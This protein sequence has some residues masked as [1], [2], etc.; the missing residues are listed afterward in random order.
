MTRCDVDP[1]LISS[2]SPLVQGAHPSPER[3]GPGDTEDGSNQ[4][5]VPPAAQ[6]RGMWVAISFHLFDDMCEA[7]L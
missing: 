1:C 3:G 4:L 2:I 7:P 6:S 5:H